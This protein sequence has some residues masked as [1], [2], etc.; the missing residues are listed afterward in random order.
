MNLFGKPIYINSS[1]KVSVMRSLGENPTEIELQMMVNEADADGNGVVDFFE[2]MT[3]MQRQAG[4]TDP[5]EGMREAFRVIY[6]VFRFYW[7][8]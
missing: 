8:S 3:L 5:D 1:E 6:T 7:K 4:K 2:F